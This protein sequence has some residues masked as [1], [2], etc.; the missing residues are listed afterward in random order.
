LVFDGVLCFELGFINGESSESSCL[1]FSDHDCVFE[2]GNEVSGFLSED[3]ERD[4]QLVLETLLDADSGCDGIFEGV[5]S[6]A[7]GGVSFEYVV[8]ELPALFDFEVVCPI[9]GSLVDCAPQVTF[10]GLAFSTAHEHI[11]SED[12]MDCKLLGVHS[13][14]EGLL[15]YDHLVTVDQ[16]LLQLVGKH[17]LQRMHLVGITDLLDNFGHLVVG[18]SGLQESE[19]SL[20]SFVGGEDDVCLFASD[21]RI[22]IGLDDEGV[23]DE[24]REAIDMCSEFNFEEVSLLDGGGVFL[25]GRIIAA[26][27][28]DGDGGGEGESLENWF[29]VIDFR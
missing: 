22:F 25:E 18:V 3:G 5:E 12:V 23:C 1:S 26:D 17:A 11:Q 7:E 2:L 16:V 6:E 20:C 10:F 27:L 21:G 19:G 13:L 28:I 24:G 29:F 9:E 14:V 15:V 4:E 8:E